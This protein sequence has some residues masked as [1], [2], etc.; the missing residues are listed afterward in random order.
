MQNIV[1][2]KD[3]AW[4]IIRQF[5]YIQKVQKSHALVYKIILSVCLCSPGGEGSKLIGEGSKLI[6]EGSKLIGEGSKQI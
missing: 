3:S 1:V 4:P 5:A 2:D 6:G